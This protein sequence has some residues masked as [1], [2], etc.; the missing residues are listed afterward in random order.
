[1]PKFQVVVPW[2]GVKQGDVVELDRVHPS[3]A[4]NVRLASSAAE[5]T[6]SAPLAKSEEDDFEPNPSNGEVV[7]T[8]TETEF[9]FETVRDDI[10]EEL[11]DMDGVEY[12][13]NAPAAD[14][15][16]LLP[17]EVREAII[18]GAQ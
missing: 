15:A 1:M 18:L 14:L 17:Q 5:L 6:E 9:D 7:D 11:Q 10:L 16:A 12:D 4:A 8:E 3:L 13:E 2:F